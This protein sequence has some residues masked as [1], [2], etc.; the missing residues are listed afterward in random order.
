MGKKIKLV[1][2]KLGRHQAHGMVHNFDRD[3]PLIEIDERLKGHERLVI[4]C[5]EALHCAFPKMPEE[6]IIAHSKLIASVI[7]SGNYRRVDL[8]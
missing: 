1:E 8:G 2:R 4:L 3:N 6:N 7:W 5:H